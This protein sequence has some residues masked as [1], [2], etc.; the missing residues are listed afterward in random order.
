M[1]TRRCACIAPSVT[2]PQ[3]APGL[4]HLRRDSAMHTAFCEIL[5]GSDSLPSYASNHAWSCNARC[6]RCPRAMCCAEYHTKYPGCRIYRAP[7][8]PSAAPENRHGHRRALGWTYLPQ[9]G[10]DVRA[11]VPHGLVCKRRL[12]VVIRDVATPLHGARVRMHADA[13]CLAAK[14]HGRS[15]LDST[16]QRRWPAELHPLAPASTREYP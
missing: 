8:P 15:A 12:T 1:C 10:L 9:H 13:A 4:P 7:T 3:S 11:P 6:V 14:R 2:P 16:L 5:V